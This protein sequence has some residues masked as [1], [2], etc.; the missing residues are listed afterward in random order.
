MKSFRDRMSNHTFA[1]SL[2]LAFS[3]CTVGCQP[4]EVTS[5]KIYIRNND[6]DRAIAQLEQAVKSDPNN[7]EAH[8]LLGQACGYKKRYKEMVTE[9]DISL[10]ISNKFLPQISAERERHWV[11]KYNAAIIALDKKDYATAQNHL[12]LAAI[13]DHSKHEAHKKLAAAYLLT[14]DA[15][16]AR[17]IYTKLLE[18]NPT[19]VNLLSSLANIYYSEEKYHDAVSVLKKILDIEPGHRDALAN[20]ALSYDALGEQEA[21][22]RAFEVAIAAN[23]LDVD[24]VFLFGEHH[25]KAENYQQAIQLFERVLELQPNDFEATVNIGNAYLSMAETLRKQL[26]TANNGSST[27]TEVQQLKQDAIANYKKAV[28]Y[29]EKALEI[30][31]DQPH[32]WRNLGVACINSGQKQRGEEA[33]LKVE[34]LKLNSSK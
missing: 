31:P 11:D 19:D 14:G 9:F 24:L 21:A 29:L 20:L 27:P 15:N 25:Y 30:H 1:L 2:T 22:A 13:I 23:S 28:P 16:K 6:W 3:L 34:E 5:A 18:N 7:A 26:Q 10:K 8:F 4:K 12:L 17:V 33:F 32:I